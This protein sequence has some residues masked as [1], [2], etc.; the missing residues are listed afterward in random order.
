MFVTVAS[1]GADRAGGRFSCRLQGIRSRIAMVSFSS[2]GLKHHEPSA[3][4]L[5]ERH[6][7]AGLCDDQAASRSPLGASIRSLAGVLPQIAI[8]RGFA[9]SGTTR[10][11][12]ML[13]IESIW[14]CEVAVPQLELDAIV[15]CVIDSAELDL[16]S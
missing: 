4:A 13:T 9:A 10:F 2:A 6:R 15:C 12:W 16:G 5:K 7:R 1:L 11:S 14:L 3:A 8:L